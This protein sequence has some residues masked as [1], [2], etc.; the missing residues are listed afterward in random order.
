[1]LKMETRVVSSLEKVFCG[2]VF[3]GERLEKISALKGERVSFQIAVCCS[4]IA[5]VEISC[6]DA[7]DLEHQITFREVQSVPSLM[8]ALPEDT[9]TLRT[10]PL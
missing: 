3:K 6:A 2:S 4:D 7:K 8:P 10:E 9:F 5:L 1:M